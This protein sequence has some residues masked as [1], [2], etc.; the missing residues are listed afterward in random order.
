MMGKLLAF[1]A[2]FRKGRQVA[3]PAA[4][5]AGQITGSVLAGLLGAIV[6]LAKV[7]NYELP[8]NDEQLLAIGSAI[9][10]I[11]G[12]FISPAI[13]TATT[14]KVGLRAKNEVSAKTQ[15]SVGGHKIG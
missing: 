8:L 13:T 5:K 11:F 10:A 14:E 9:V 7:F 3:N 4:W 6:A 15:H 2:V 12:L 1:L